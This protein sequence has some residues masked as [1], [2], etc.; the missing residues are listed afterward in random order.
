MSLRLQLK[1]IAEL[2]ENESL[3]AKNN[4]KPKKGKSKKSKIENELDD[5]D[6]VRNNTSLECKDK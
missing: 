2:V 4:E 5:D 6:S 3:E 1:Q